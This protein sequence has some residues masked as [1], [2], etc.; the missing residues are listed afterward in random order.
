MISK[1]K[2]EDEGEYACVVTIG[3]WSNKAKGKLIVRRPPDPPQ[4][5]R[6]NSCHG[7]AAELS[8]Q[9][10]KS[11]GANITY[12]IVQFSLD[13][14]YETTWF[15]FYE[16]ISGDKTT[17]QVEL[18]PYGIYMFRVLARNE[19]GTSKPSAV[20]SRKCT[21]PPD[22]PDRNPSKVRTRTDKKGFLVI[23]WEPLHRLSF[24]G[25]GFCYIVL[26]RR[27]GSLAWNSAVVNGTYASRFEQEVEDVYGSY[28]IQ[29]K[30][31]NDMGEAHQPAFIYKGHSFEAEPQV[32]VSGFQLDKQRPVQESTAHF[33]WEHVDSED[34]KMNGKF[35]GYKI[36]YWQWDEGESSK[37]QV[38][39]PVDTFIPGGVEF[40]GSV[41]DLPAYSSF[42]FQV[43]VANQHY[44]GPPS[45]T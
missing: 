3:D 10:G 24:H 2:P 39:I 27:K 1:V 33:K 31:N 21:T 19:V 42:K 43:V 28:E 40:K 45:D 30:S 12:Y 9:P 8:W 6:V 14:K 7:N 35:K 11:N 17:S 4:D 22:R 44:N 41:S 18:S 34:R 26:W 32:V 37:K 25:P 5:V 36:I 38:H 15:D 13:D 23:E 29:V 16:E 20:P